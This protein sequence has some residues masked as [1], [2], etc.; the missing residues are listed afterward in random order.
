MSGRALAL[1]FG[2][3]GGQGLQLS[4]RILAAALL[5]AGRCIALSQSYEP[6]SRGGVSRSDI[7]V[8]AGSDP[9]DYPLAEALDYLVLLDEVA[10]GSL[11]LVRPGGR[12]LADADR[13]ESGGEAARRLPFTAL[14]RSLGNERVANIVALGALIGAGAVCPPE[15]VEAAVR[16]E[17][18]RK[19]LDTNIAALAAGRRL[20]LAD[21][22]PPGANAIAGFEGRVNG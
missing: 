9:V 17:T 5:R 18:P 14:A 11:R 12:V 7:V 13:V 19:F 16:A 22:E 4:A 8:G 10:A 6:T 20:A 21:A 3:S 15:A 1:R 2:G